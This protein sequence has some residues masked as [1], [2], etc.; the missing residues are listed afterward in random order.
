MLLITL[1]FLFFYDNLVLSNSLPLQKAAN[2]YLKMR[3]WN[4]GCQGSD[5]K[6][7]L[8]CGGTNYKALSNVEYLIEGYEV[9]KLYVPYRNWSITSQEIGHFENG[10]SDSHMPVRQK[11]LNSHVCEQSCANERTL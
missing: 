10:L 1:R 7:N 3:T 9:C 8:L 2:R 11:L 5:K 4:L 6:R